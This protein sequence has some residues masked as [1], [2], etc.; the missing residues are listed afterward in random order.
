GNYHNADG[1]LHGFLLRKG[2]FETIDGPNATYTTAAGI[3]PNG[4]I[5][6]VYIDSAGHHGYRIVRGVFRAID[7][8][9]A[10]LTGA[11]GL[12]PGGDVVGRDIDLNGNGHGF[13]SPIP[14]RDD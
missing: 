6:G 11:Y 7:G 9:N 10:L 5:A 14:E 12:K 8:S 3:T 2:R 4:G 1:V 13:F